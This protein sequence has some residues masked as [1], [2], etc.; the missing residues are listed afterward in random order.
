[1]SISQRFNYCIDS[2][3]T[4]RIVTPSVVVSG[5]II[6]EG[7]Q[8]I[9]DL[10]LR[11]TSGNYSRQ[12][13]SV[14]R[15]DVEAIYPQQSAMGFHQVLSILEL[16]TQDSYFISFSLAGE[17]CQFP[18]HLSI[19][20]EAIATLRKAKA[21]KLNKIKQVLQ[22]PICGSAVLTAVERRLHC[23]NCQSEFSF[24]DS[25]YN[26]LNSELIEKGKIKTTENVSAFG[27]DPVATE[28]ISQFVDGLIL[29]NGCGLKNKYYENIV[30]FEI[31]EYPT[32][33]V[34]GIGENLPFKSESF[35]AVFSFLVLEHVRNPFD[36]A[37]EI[38]RVVKPG[39]TIY[40]IAPFLQPFHGYPDHY[41]NMTSN[42]LKNLFADRVEIVKCDVYPKALPIACLTWFLNA[43]LRGL[44]QP[45]AEKFKN[46]KVGELLGHHREYNDADFVTELSPKVNDELACANY[47]IGR[48]I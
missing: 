28:Y 34:V 16:P 4:D 15:P 12:L 30:N 26:F 39:G 36:C 18:I 48:K 7:G 37:R 19:S 11:T 32:T 27:Y 31:V 3:Q 44:P 29:D 2:P 42:G 6:W 24:N 20:E 17:T 14:S 35:D 5:W 23:D 33:D 47:L 9:A 13:N 22:C 38:L 1:M 25:C 41:Y 46:M 45:V 43:Y 10:N 21:Q 40:T 8:A